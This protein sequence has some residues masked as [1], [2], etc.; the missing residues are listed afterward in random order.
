[1]GYA[2][3][4]QPATNGILTINNGGTVSAAGSVYSNYSVSIAPPSNPVPGSGSI[5]VNAGGSMTA[6]TLF[7]RNSDITGGGTITA[8]GLASD[9]NLTFD[10]SAQTTTSF[11]GVL[12]N[13]DLHASTGNGALIAGYYDQSNATVNIRNG[14]VVYSGQGMSAGACNRAAAGYLPGA[15]LGTI[16]VDGPTTKWINGNGNYMIAG[17]AGTGYMYITNGGSVTTGTTSGRA[18]GLYG[19]RVRSDPGRQRIDLYAQRIYPGYGT[20]SNGTL[21]VTNGGVASASQFDENYSTADRRP[22]QTGQRHPQGTRSVG[23]SFV[24]SSNS[25]TGSVQINAGGGTFDTNGFANSVTVPIVP[26]NPRR[27]PDQD[28]SR[29]AHP[30]G[31][32][33][34]IP[35]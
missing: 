33:I 19:Q 17:Y 23:G 5:V 25:A 1:M 21:L 26:G 30:Y 6:M 28:R 10:N 4:G 14:T 13:V 22:H 34:L 20:G 31:L 3:Q 18:Y 7:S 8:Y 24:F 16:N 35:A 27:R 15:A 9:Q 2:T 32:P 11:G 12:T 29:H